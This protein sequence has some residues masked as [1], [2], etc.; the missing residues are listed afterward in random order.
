MCQPRPQPSSADRCRNFEPS[1]IPVGLPKEE[2]AHGACS[3]EIL[4]EV[5]LEVNCAKFCY[6]EPAGSCVAFYFNKAKK[7]CRLVLYTDAT[8]NMV[9]AR[10]WKKFI[11]KK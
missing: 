6:R 11:L 7:E 2:F 4:R 5:G 1:P 3:K 10:G 9:D 8:I